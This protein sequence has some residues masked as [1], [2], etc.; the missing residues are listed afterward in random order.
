MESRFVA[1][2]CCPLPF[3]SSGQLSCHLGKVA[4][5]DTVTKLGWKVDIRTHPVKV[6]IER[7][8]NE[9]WHSLTADSIDREVPELVEEND[10]VASIRLISSLPDD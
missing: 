6:I 8:L 7:L 9:D 1:A 2:P 5:Y 10:C 3:I 4:R